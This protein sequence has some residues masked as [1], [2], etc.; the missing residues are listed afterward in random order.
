MPITILFSVRYVVRTGLLER[1]ARSCEPVLALSWD[2]PDL[3]EELGAAGVEVVRLPEPRVDAPTLALLHLLEV[4]FLRRLASPSTPIDRARRHVGRSRSVRARR[5][6]SWQRTRLRTLAPGHE[7]RVRAELAAAVPTG[8]NLDENRRFLADHRIDAVFSVT[9]FTEQERVVLLAAEA[10]GLPACTSILS[11]DNITTRPPLPIRFHRYLVWNAFNRDEVLRGYPGVGAHQVEVVGPAQFDFYR[12]PAY[13]EDRTRWRARS[14]LGEHPVVLYGAG[15]PEVAPH[16]AQHVQHLCDAVDRGELPAD[17]RILVRRHPVDRPGRWERFAHHPAVV[18]DDPG[19]VGDTPG[20]PG[21]VGI[22]HDQ[23][24]GLCST[25]AHTDV[26]VNVSSTL[27]LDGAFFHKPQIGPAYD[28]ADGRRFHRTARDL[29]R[30]EHFLPIVASGGLEVPSTPEELVATVARA[31]ADPGRLE[32]QRRA[33]LDAL[34]TYTDGR[35]TERVAAA[36]ED[37]LRHHLGAG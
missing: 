15:P 12:D 25:L 16:E 4:H 18:I 6:A 31:L 27:T 37:F 3:V 2:D 28:V 17:L 7:A 19:R 11:F 8:T 29:Y 5:W 22:G 30:R 1:L 9:P 26:H 36:V 24:V 20:R 13:V 32:P 34:C 33:M 23:I 21:Q 35:C 10:A 14:G